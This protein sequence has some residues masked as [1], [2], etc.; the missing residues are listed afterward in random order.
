M[1]KTI[2]RRFVKAGNVRARRGDKPGIEG[3][4]SMFNEPF[5]NGWFIETIVPGAFA[6]A[7]K[8]KQDVRCLFNHN[9][10]HVLG[11]TK[12]DTL[13]LSEDKTGLRYECDLN[14]ETRVAA[15]VLAMIERGDLDGCSF[16]FNVNKQSWR[17]EKDDRGHVTQYRDIEDV[18]LFD[19]GPV[20]YPA[21]EGT[22]VSTRSLWPTGIPDEVRGHV[23]ELREDDP[24]K[25]VDGEVLRADAFLIVGDS[26]DPE[27]WHLPWKFST[28]EKTKSHLRDALA[29]FDQVQGVDAEAKKKAHARLVELCKEHGIDVDEKDDDGA[30][31]TMQA[32]EMRRMR[33]RL[34]KAS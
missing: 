25:T 1:S 12:S 30:R 32:E 6:R 14:A 9:P 24:H 17:E 10:D 21:Y 11:R 5:D 33:L 18:E 22:S 20:T 3:Y 13:R 29:R 26:K 2:E 28:E 31:A 34:A 7:L 19:V 15:D 8:E 16:A 4:A 27:T 23:A